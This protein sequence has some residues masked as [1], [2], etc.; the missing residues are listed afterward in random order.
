VGSLRTA[1]GAWGR[2]MGWVPRSATVPPSRRLLRCE[3][4]RGSAGGIETTESRPRLAEQSCGSGE[5]SRRTSQAPP[6][7]CWRSQTARTTRRESECASRSIPSSARSPPAA[8]GGPTATRPRSPST[9]R[10]RCS[11][12]RSSLR[13]RIAP[14]RQCAAAASS[15]A[16]S[17]VMEAGPKPRGRHSPRATPSASRRRPGRRWRCLLRGALLRPQSPAR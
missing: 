15:S 14:P 16:S 7:S 2:A 11:R 10:W 17:S 1:P 4:S 3:R 9:P 12:S 8:A 5:S 13:M 6:P